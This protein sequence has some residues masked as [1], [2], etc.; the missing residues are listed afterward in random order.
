M[1]KNMAGKKQKTVPKT[2]S[3]DEFPPLSSDSD[4]HAVIDQSQSGN[5][6]ALKSSTSKQSD[7]IEKPNIIDGIIQCK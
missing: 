3:D 4:T 5:I 6:V 2:S 7:M 1:D